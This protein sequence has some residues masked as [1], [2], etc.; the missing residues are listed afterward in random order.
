MGKIYYESDIR[1]ISSGE[2]SSKVGKVRIKKDDGSIEELKGK[3]LRDYLMRGARGGKSETTIKK[4]LIEDGV[5]G[6]QEKKRG[7]I[8]S[9]LKGGETSLKDKT[10]EKQKIRLKKKAF[11]QS[12]RAADTLAESRKNPL[13][14]V[15]KNVSYLGIGV[16]GRE[17][18]VAVGSKK[19]SEDDT[20]I[21][22]GKAS[23][24]Q[25]PVSV[26]GGLGVASKPADAK[27]N[28]VI[29]GNFGNRGVSRGVPSIG[30]KKAGNF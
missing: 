22:G 23:I 2:L 19:L 10:Q 14:S 6:A 30:I 1:K 18:G 28:N 13:A 20:R 12:G 24:G 29:R 21:Q 27:P 15:E 5:G 16:K 11:V 17:Y 9:V 26:A 7:K 3:T 8:L 4:S 25:N